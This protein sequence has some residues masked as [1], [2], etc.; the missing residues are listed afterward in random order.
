MALRSAKTASCV[1]LLFAAALPAQ[2]IKFDARHEHLRKGCLGTFTVTGEGVSFSGAKHA[3]QWKFEDIQ[4]LSLGARRIRVL[5]YRDSRLRLGAD[6]AYEF[7]GTV[8]QEVYSLWKDKLDQR[9]VAEL[10]DPAVEARFSVPAKHVK[11]L[12]GSEGTITF[13]V[14]RIVYSSGEPGDSRTWRFQDIEDLSSS[15]PFQLTVTTFE[16][17]R[18]HYNDRKDFNFQLKQPLSQARFD[19]LWRNIVLNRRTQ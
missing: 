5:T 10:A 16:R 3:F 4:E 15:G 17:A 1:I 2:E 12:K 9:F 18:G 11:R 6:R 19:E 13:A 7:K 8:P 14:D